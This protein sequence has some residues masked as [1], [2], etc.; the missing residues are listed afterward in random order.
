MRNITRNIDLFDLKVF[1]NVNLKENGKVNE[2]TVIFLKE[3]IYPNTIVITDI[4]NANSTGVSFMVDFFNCNTGS[5]RDNNDN[6]IRFY[7]PIHL[8]FE[9]GA[10]GHEFRFSNVSRNAYGTIMYNEGTVILDNVRFGSS[11]LA[12]AIFGEYF[13]IYNAYRF[14]FEDTKELSRGVLDLSK[15][16]IQ[17][18]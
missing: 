2:K 14:L 12:F 9:S 15:Y 7:Q 6:I 4:I 13:S 11:D 17:V 1:P 5:Y 18:L 10:N 16:S 3:P 8:S